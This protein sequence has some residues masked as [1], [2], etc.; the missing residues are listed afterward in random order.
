[1]YLPAP[2][3]FCKW[4]VTVGLILFAGPSP[5][6]SVGEFRASFILVGGVYHTR[7]KQERFCGDEFGLHPA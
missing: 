5:T 3:T 4:R 6:V 2:I 1:M 7:N